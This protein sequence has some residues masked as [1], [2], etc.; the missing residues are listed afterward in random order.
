MCGGKS[1]RFGSAGHKSETTVNGYPL[2]YHVIEYWKQY[3]D[4]FVFV[5]KHGKEA[6][7]DYISTLPIECHFVEPDRL[8]GIADGLSYAEHLIDGP[9]IMVLGDCFCCGEFDMSDGFHYGI[10]V[11]D[12]E[13]TQI[14]QNYS[15]TLDESNFVSQVEE[16]P[17]TVQSNLC[18]TGFYFFQKNIFDF[19]RKT[20]PSARTGELEITDV[21]QTLLGESVPL[22]GV[23]LDGVYVNVTRPADLRQVESA[24]A[25]TP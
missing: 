1:T 23:N 22:K 8:G 5:V 19:I 4:E 18:G 14:Q 2:I 24:L 3:A 7:V 10:G 21:L 11:I 13:P 9:F 17:E 12:S 16:K 15:V 6:M 25:L 20:N